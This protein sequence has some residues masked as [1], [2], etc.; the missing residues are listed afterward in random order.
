MKEEEKMLLKAAE[1]LG[2]R[3]DLVRV[4]GLSLDEDVEEGVYLIR[5]LSHNRA[6]VA[7]AHVEA[8]GAVAVNNWRALAAGWNKAVAL[9]MLRASGLPIPKTR[10]A[11]A[12][13]D[14]KELI[15]K[16]AFG[17]WGRKVALARSKE[18]VE[19]LLRGA[20][21]DEVYLVQERIGD[22]TDIR[23]F[24][25]GY[26]V[27][28]AMIRRPPPGDWRSNAAR[29]GIVEGVRLSPELES[30]A[31]KAA[32][33]LNAEYAGVDIL[34]GEGAYYVGEVNMVPEFKAVSRASGVDV[35]EE[36]VKYVREMEKR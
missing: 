14:S 30:L 2:A 31:V 10:L 17:S 22:G 5:T 3:M 21:P 28:A 15:V 32:R 16:P 33:A 24:V 8:S 27:V 23:A 1:R 11:P 35:A 29:G 20:D 26:R 7:A 34:I 12:A 9:A 13:P 4:E 25:I 19:A 36:L 18:D 6:V